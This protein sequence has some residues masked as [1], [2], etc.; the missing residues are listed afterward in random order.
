MTSGWI[1]VQSIATFS[2]A[3][4]AVIGLGAGYVALEQTSKDLGKLA[5]TTNLVVNQTTDVVERQQEF[6]ENLPES[7]QEIFRHRPFPVIDGPNVVNP[8]EVIALARP[9]TEL[10]IDQLFE[11]FVPAE[12]LFPL[13]RAEYPAELI[14]IQQFRVHQ[15][16]ALLQGGLFGQ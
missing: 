3:I 7:V 2:I 16:L 14:P 15:L 4:V 12:P 13:H 6:I 11:G 8:N 9:E 5:D 1:K 10:V